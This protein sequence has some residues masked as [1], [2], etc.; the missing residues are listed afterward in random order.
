[1]KHNTKLQANLKV[2]LGFGIG[3][4]F[5][6]VFVFQNC[7][8][9]MDEEEQASEAEILA[10][11]SPNL[12]CMNES[13][14]YSPLTK[15]IS[16][17][18][19]ETLYCEFDPSNYPDLAMNLKDMDTG[20][21]DRDLPFNLEEIEN[22]GWVKGKM[23]SGKPGLLFRWRPDVLTIKR[24]TSYIYVSELDRTILESVDVTVLP[25]K[26][27]N[28]G[29]KAKGANTALSK[30]VTIRASQTLYC[31]MDKYD[32]ITT[33]RQ[34]VATGQFDSPQ[35]VPLAQQHWVLGTRLNGEPGYTLEI[36]PADVTGA[37][38]IKGHVFLTL[39]DGNVLGEFADITFTFAP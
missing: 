34:D 13:I 1:M 18:T 28:L 19:G 24:F 31:E 27:L 9:N 7:A 17:H 21:Y 39:G 32:N 33:Y 15:K 16:V 2:K 12:R 23:K 3:A 36:P 35:P 26:T 10:A 37:S 29:C 25:P 11:K 22:N 14:V 20:V 6:L 38:R 5:T 4:L 30:T 8:T